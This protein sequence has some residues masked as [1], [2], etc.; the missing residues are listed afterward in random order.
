MPQFITQ[1]PGIP[2]RVNPQE[3]ISGFT[4]KVGRPPTQAEYQEMVNGFSRSK[5]ITQGT[6]DGVINIVG[7]KASD[8]DNQ[9]RQIVQATTGKPPTPEEFNSLMDQFAPQGG[10]GTFRAENIR[11]FV[12]GEQTRTKEA[13]QKAEQQKLIDEQKTREQQFVQE[14]TRLAQEN[15]TR[16][17]RES[18]LDQAAAS[19]G[20]VSPSEL[21]QLRAILEQQGGIGTP[22]S[23]SL[24]QGLQ[25]IL[26]RRQEDILK[27]T[28]GFDQLRQSLAGQFQKSRESLGQQTEQALQQYGQTAQTV[29]D[30]VLNQV[31]P[32][33]QSQLAARGLETGGG[34]FQSA[35]AK[36][37]TELETQKQEDLGQRRLA[38]RG[39]LAE[40]QSADER[41]LSNLQMQQSEIQRQK[42]E[43]DKLAREGRLDQQTLG[44]LQQQV[45]AYN[46]AYATAN[47][48]EQ[49]VA[50]FGQQIQ[51]LGQQQNFE[52]LQNQ[53][54][55]TQ[56]QM[57]QDLASRQFEQQMAF[58]QQQFQAQQAAANKK[59]SW[60]SQAV[61]IA[62]PLAGAYLGSMVGQPGAGY[63]AGSQVA[64]GL[65][66]RSQFQPSYGSPT[67]SFIYGRGY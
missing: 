29:Q 52:S 33:I 12:E 67:N 1:D 21:A 32:Q 49:N 36:F 11:G 6:I 61:G 7:G 40:T 27:Q 28:Q 39:G 3:L 44:R 31:L 45:D 34:A 13:T 55:R 9:I 62:A 63:A 50:G 38:L 30:R 15:Q 18:K 16:L 53:F 22:E 2:S 51:G 59:P 17:G 64:G 54:N 14:Q 56:Q 26:G 20:G 57:Q 43:A 46:Q 58:Q 60:L 41:F 37:G 10:S 25:G 65:N 24:E 5:R 42:E 48:R 47:Q 4:S 66:L 19:L 35:A 8:T 23:Q